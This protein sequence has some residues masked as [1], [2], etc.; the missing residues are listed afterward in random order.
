M[1][2][3]GGP[4]YMITTEQAPTGRSAGSVAWA[5]LANTSYWIDPTK[6]VAGVIL[7]QILPF[8]DTRA[9]ELFAQFERAMY[10]GAVA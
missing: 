10:A 2:K 8:A 4:G 6:K 5:G 3:K 7:T 1:V 9:L